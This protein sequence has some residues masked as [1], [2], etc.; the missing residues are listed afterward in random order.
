MLRNG[1]CTSVL[2]TWYVFILNCHWISAQTVIID[3]TDRGTYSSAGFHNPANPNYVVGDIRGTGGDGDSRNFFV[4]DLAGITKPIVS[5][6]LALSVPSQ[7]AGPGF[8]SPDLSE[9]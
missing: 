1:A 9:N 4:F 7:I 8:S 5:A 6:K 2:I 3:Y